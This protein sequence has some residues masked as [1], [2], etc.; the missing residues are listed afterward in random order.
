MRKNIVRYLTASLSDASL[1]ILVNFG[2]SQMSGYL[3]VLSAI[4]SKCCQDL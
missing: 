1:I 3:K 2:F 4:T